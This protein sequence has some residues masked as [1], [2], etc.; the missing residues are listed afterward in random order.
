VTF[1]ERVLAALAHRQ[2]D[3][4][5]LGEIE[6]DGPIVEAVLGRPTYYRNGL[7][8]V[9]AF[10]DGR[11]DEV[12]DSIKRDYVEF[13]RVTGMDLVSFAMEIVPGR[14]ADCSPQDPLK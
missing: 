4:V 7:K 1:K 3:R 10:L 13:V 11:R 9:L 8:A 6:I 12:V 14:E 5:P 2:P